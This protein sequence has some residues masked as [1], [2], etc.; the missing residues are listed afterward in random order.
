MA[1]IPQSDKQQLLIQI[2]DVPQLQHEETTPQCAKA[3]NEMVSTSRAGTWMLPTPNQKF[4][5]AK[6]YKENWTDLV[7]QPTFRATT[8][9]NTDEK[10]ELYFADAQTP[11]RIY[12]MIKIKRISDVDNAE[13]TFRCKF[14][15]Y[16]DWLLSQKEYESYVQTKPGTNWIPSFVPNYDFT[17]IVE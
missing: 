12:C 4:E 9:T 10:D 14:H 7:Q 16:F 3:T 15:I 11:R 17:N 8:S 13:Q 6:S 5:I 1:E 2:T